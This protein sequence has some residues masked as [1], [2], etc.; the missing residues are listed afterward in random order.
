MGFQQKDTSLKCLLFFKAY[1]SFSQVFFCC[2]TFVTKVFAGTFVTKVFAGTFVTK[3]FAGTFVTKVFAGTFVPKAFVF[4][5]TFVYQPAQ[6]LLNPIFSMGLLTVAFL[7]KAR[8]LPGFKEL[9]TCLLKQL[10]NQW[11]LLWSA[12]QFPICSG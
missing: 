7:T 10:S 5:G 9:G 12:F 4:A 2:S 6:H 1:I 11:L 3:V 8:F